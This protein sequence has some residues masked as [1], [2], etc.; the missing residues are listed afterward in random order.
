MPV[1]L[2][3]RAAPGHDAHVRA[4]GDQRRL[5]PAGGAQRGHV[6]HP[7]R[8]L[9]QGRAAPRR[10]QVLHRPQGEEARDGARRRGGAAEEGSFGGR[11]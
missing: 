9:L 8:L 3:R 7:L 6:R 4:A 1:R 5:Q 10:L 11:A 2:R